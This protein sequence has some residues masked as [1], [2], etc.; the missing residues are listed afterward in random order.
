MKIAVLSPIHWRTPPRIYGPWELIASYV[1][2]GMVKKG[3]E[4]TLYATGDS[5]TKARLRSIC[6]RPIMEDSS[7][8][9]KVYQYLHTSLALEEADQFDIIHN[10]YDAYPLAFSKLIKTPIVTTLHG[11]SSQT[12]TIYQ[13]YPRSPLVSISYSQREASPGLSYIANVYHGIPLNEYPFNDK[14]EDYFCYLGRIS[15]TKGVDL[16]IELAQK[17]KI[18]FLMAGLIAEEEKDFF[19][20]FVKPR[21]NRDIRYLGNLGEEKKEVLRKSRGLIHLTRRNEDFG[22]TLIEA[23]AGGTPVIGMNHGSIPEIVEDQK[24]GFVVSSLEEAEKTIQKIDKIDRRACRERVEE[25][26]SLEKMID[27]YE[28]VYQTII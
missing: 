15:P 11:F 7:L 5:V 24:T 17:K 23:M 28:K 1:A 3:H 9:L 8:D 16:A 19:N 13:K 18:K 12:P 14:P 6:P 27:G 20:Q 4:V 26:F 25:Y 2:E 10:H 22:L 21:L